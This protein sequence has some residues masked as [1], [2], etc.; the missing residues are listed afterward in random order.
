VKK[1]DKIEALEIQ[2][3]RIYED[4]TVRGISEQGMKI[5]H[6]GGAATI[7]VEE[8]P[9]Y[10]HLFKKFKKPE[11]EPV[12]EV[13]QNAAEEPSESISAWTP[14]SVEDVMDCSLF[15]KVSDGVGKNGG[16]T[17]WTGSAFLVNHGKTTYIYSNVHNFDGA[18]KFQILDRQGVRYSDFVSVEV[19]A[20]GYGY[21]QANKWGGDI[22]RIRLRKYREK[23]LTIETS[24]INPTKSG[25]RKIVV[26]GN[27]RGEGV[28]TRLE[29]VIRSVDKYG[30]IHHTAATESGNSGSPIVDLDTFKVLGILTWGSYDSKNPLQQIW[31]SK[32]PENRAAKAS[33]ANLSSVKYTRCSFL[34][35]YK[36]RIMINELKK[37]ARLMG[38]M[39][40]LVPA[41]HGI[42]LNRTAVVM[43]DYDVG[44]IVNESKGNPILTEL[45]ALDKWLS[46]KGKSNIGIS[47]QD[48]LKQYITSYSKCLRIIQQQRKAYG[49]V[50]NMTFYMKCHLK[51]TRALDICIAYE[52]STARSI[53]WY[54]QQRGTEGKPFP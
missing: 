39:D 50:S 46:A 18:K 51:N 11:E 14:S 26:T 37:T 54:R 43:G 28:I 6:K 35:L 49:G 23:A 8:L 12:P 31:S 53:Q 10:A 9:Q 19:A 47:N 2:S 21:F 7:P 41:K 17:K 13:P 48:M 24:A 25:Q 15:V 40:V 52:K 4:V 29:G 16:T 27:T 32:D 36:Q 38:L 3:G 1:G 45:I 5:F 30:V 33:G 22:I 42:F 44:A 34:A 20:D